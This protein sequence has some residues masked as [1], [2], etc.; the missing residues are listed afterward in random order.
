MKKI[1]KQKNVIY[2]LCPICGN[3]VELPAEKGFH[4]CPNCKNLILACAMCDTDNT[5]CSNCNY[6]KELKEIDNIAK[7]LYD[8]LWYT[9]EQKKQI[10][11]GL[12]KYKKENNL[13]LSQLRN[14]CWDDSCD[15]FNY[16]FG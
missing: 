15:I 2:E 14:K 5:S 9:D 16:I 1:K 12:V 11:T 6:E 10:H 3:E 7:E 8:G 4:E 13:S